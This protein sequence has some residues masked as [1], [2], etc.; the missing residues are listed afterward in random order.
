M[1]TS[2]D[3]DSETD[4]ADVDQDADFGWGPPLREHQTELMSGRKIL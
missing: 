2:G 3:L 1:F 4:D